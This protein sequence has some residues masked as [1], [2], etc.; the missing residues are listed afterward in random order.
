M[1]QQRYTVHDSVKLRPYP[2]PDCQQMPIGGM[3]ATGAWVVKCRNPVH[4][5]S[6]VEM[7]ERLAV[8]KWNE[9][10]LQIQQERA[11]VNAKDHFWF[12]RLR[13][14]VLKCCGNPDNLDVIHF[15]NNVMK[16]TCKKCGR[17]H[18]TVM[19]EPGIIGF[20]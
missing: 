9:W 17:S 11:K 19:A 4:S 15:P 1:E 6:S 10:A 12:L 20:R 7:S 5:N 3:A 16:A 8:E 14:D 2:C 13:A 18:R